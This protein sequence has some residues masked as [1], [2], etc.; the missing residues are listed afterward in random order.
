LWN[1]FLGAKV[2][3]N[4]CHCGHHPLR[5]VMVAPSMVRDIRDAN[6]LSVWRVAL[7]TLRSADAWYIIGYSLPPGDIAIRS[8]L[9][10][11]YHARDVS[12]HLE[13]VQHSEATYPNYRLLFKLPK[14]QFHAG[15]LVAFLKGRSSDGHIRL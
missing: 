10:R 8:L 3:D 11:A 6:L 5:A 1:Q 9:I 14:A 15:G 7:E 2:D 13:V 12:P 4:T